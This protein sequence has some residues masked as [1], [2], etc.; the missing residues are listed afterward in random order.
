MFI[1]EYDA[2]THYIALALAISSL[3]YFCSMRRR[4]M[5][6]CAHLG[7]IAQKLFEGLQT[8]QNFES[9]RKGTH[10][11]ATFERERRY[12][13]INTGFDLWKSPCLSRFAQCS[14]DCNFVEGGVVPVMVRAGNVM[15]SRG[16]RSSLRSRVILFIAKAAIASAMTCGSG[17][18]MLV[19]LS[20]SCSSSKDSL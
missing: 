4:T 14:S 7:S 11:F 5:K 16:C 1:L 8:S 3:I 6:T 19:N 18:F 20:S 17:S 15:A 2:T 9:V 10:P 12:I 13:T